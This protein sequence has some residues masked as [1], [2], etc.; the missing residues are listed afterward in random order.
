MASGFVVSSQARVTSNFAVA[1]IPRVL[2]TKCRNSLI[3]SQLC[4]SRAPSNRFFCECS[5]LQDPVNFI[6][7]KEV[8]S[9]RMAMAG[10]KPHHR[11]G[12]S[13]T[14]HSPLAFLF[15]RSGCWENVGKEKKRKEQKFFNLQFSQTLLN[16]ALLKYFAYWALGVSGGPDS[17]ALCILTADWKTNG[18]NTAGESR[19]FIDGLLAII[20]D[21]GLRAESK[22]EANIVRH[23]VS[24]MGIRCEIAQCD[25][26]DGKPKQG[27]LQEA[28]REMR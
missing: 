22:D 17:M 15:S 9:R 21:H 14:S 8:F 25:W 13:L 11:I 3:S 6:K 28:A 5:H 12:H 2:S 23:R 26:L 20:V 27:H 4:S 24:D 10:L 16:L 19:G 7:Y 18:L 1:S